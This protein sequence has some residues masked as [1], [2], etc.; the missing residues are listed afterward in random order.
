ME[1][2]FPIGMDH[3]GPTPPTYDTV[4]NM[5]VLIN[6]INTSTHQQ[7]KTMQPVSQRIMSYCTA[8]ALVMYI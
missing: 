3:D 4:Y 1:H 8:C 2:D 6:Y 5:F 7:T